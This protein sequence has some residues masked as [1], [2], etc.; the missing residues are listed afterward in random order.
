MCKEY[1]GTTYHGILYGHAPILHTRIKFEGYVGA[2]DRPCK[3]N[4]N[5][6]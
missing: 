6:V 5:N 4:N 2:V 3:Y 1:Y